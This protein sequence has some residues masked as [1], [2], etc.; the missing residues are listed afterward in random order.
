LEQQGHRVIEARDGEAAT[1]MLRE[2]A[3][4]LDLVLSDVIVPGIGTSEWQREVRDQRPDLPIL[5]MSGYSR[6]EMIERGLIA[7]EQRFLQKPF[8]AG[9]LSAL[10]CQEL[11]A[12]AGPEVGR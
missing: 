5:Y 4:D 1:R 12:R 3:S 9:E 7:S 6:D 8:T 2:V 10:V 11:E